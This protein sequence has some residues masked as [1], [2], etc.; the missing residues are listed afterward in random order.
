MHQ[1][2]DL[3]LL[4][5]LI[6][7]FTINKQTQLKYKH[8]FIYNICFDVGPI[9]GSLMW[10]EDGENAPVWANDHHTLSIQPFVSTGLN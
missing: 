3:S 9:K 1:F 2:E 7:Y 6:S 10:E 4:T 8:P 5:I